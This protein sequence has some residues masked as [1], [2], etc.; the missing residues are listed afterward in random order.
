MNDDY[1]TMDTREHFVEPGSDPLIAPLNTLTS[2]SFKKDTLCAK[3]DS[4]AHI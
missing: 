3:L 4:S 2:F 1:K